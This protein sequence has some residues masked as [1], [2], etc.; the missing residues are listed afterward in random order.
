MMGSTTNH[1]AHLLTY[2]IARSGHIVNIEEVSNGLACS[3]TCPACKEPLVAKNQGDK[4]V[5]HFAHQSG[6]E[7]ELAYETMMHRLAKQRVQEAFLKAESFFLDYEY[8]SY[9]PNA[10]NCQKVHYDEVCYDIERKKV[11]LKE[12]YDSCEQEVAYDGI[13]RRSDLKL[14]SSTF[15]ERPPV[16]IEFCVTHS[17]EQEKLHSGNRIIECI[18]EEESD[19]DRIV[20]A[21]FV[22]EEQP[23]DWGTLEHPENCE[24]IMPVGKIQ[25]YG[26]KK[27]DHSNTQKNVEIQFTRFVLYE[28]GKTTCR[29]EL[30]RCK[31]IKKS[32]QN[33]IFEACF[34]GLTSF[35]VYEYAKYLCYERFHIRN[36]LLC[37]NCVERYNGTGLI[38][39][40]Y[41]HLGIPKDSKLDTSRAKTCVRFCFNKEEYDATMQS[42]QK[43]YDEL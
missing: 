27:S 38:C 25:M 33:T 19:I 4:R 16:Y 18:I 22:E 36:C 29:Q 37:K 2:A 39:T 15:P 17:S 6:A 10:N 24:E 30:C 40:H 1:R 3:C 7:C 13:R 8:R 20:K 26:F 42:G 5:H 41:K 43:E 35:G 9:C 21:G 32:R 11:N 12:Y 34:H 31:D 28:S 23:E 14:F